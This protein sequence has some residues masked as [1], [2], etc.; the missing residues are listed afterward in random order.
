M[1]LFLLITVS[2]PILGLIVALGLSFTS[3]SRPY[4]PYAAIAATGGT[5]L[6][7]LVMRWVD[8]LVVFPSLWQPSVLFRA[9]LA[10]QPD[11]VMQPFA[12][13]LA[14][15]TCS[16][17]LV[18]VG[19][20]E[21]SLPW[22]RLATI[23]TLLAVSLVVLLSANVLSLIIGW[24]IYDLV[25]VVSRVVAGDSARAAVRGLILGSL[26]TILLWMGAL[27]ADDAVGGNLWPLV[28]LDRI[29][30]VLWS[31][32]GALR[33]WLYPFHL[34][35]P[36]QLSFASPLAVPLVTGNVLGWSLWIRIALATGGRIPSGDWLPTFAGLTLVLASLMAWACERPRR[37]L[38]WIG[39]AMNGVVLLAAVLAGESAPLVLSAGGMTGMLALAGLY[40]FP[41]W[42]RKAPW[43]NLPFIVN[44]LAVLG[45]PLTLGFVSLA[46]LTGALTA[47]GYLGW[48][49]A[50]FVGQI[51]LVPALVRWISSRD[52]HTPQAPSAIIMQAL[53]VAP[54]AILLVAAGLSLPVLL[55]TADTLSL[56][57]LFSMPG[58]AGWLLWLVALAGGGILAWQDRN[59]RPRMKILLSA[60]YDFVRLEW[61]Y[62]AL[63]GALDRGLNVLR[64]SDAMIGGAGALLWSW[65]LFLILLLVWGNR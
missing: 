7:T 39:V 15:V 41:G 56:G 4:A 34:S 29:Q 40:F 42:D 54:G 63:V 13:G 38:A 26:S 45:S 30:I 51:L 28:T 62:D 32:A 31:L 50:F 17:V 12:F 10:L 19:Q 53:G 11:L 64:L 2:L 1:S 18:T 9:S 59:L 60:I 46:T 24:V 33:L 8:P 6:L 23:L 58:L 37:S 20:M 16:S 21:D 36:D 14:L 27:L 52:A 57:M 61:L 22:R 65:V 49:G 43:W 35:L 47:G 55:P 48:G 3:R 25:M 44:G 5:V